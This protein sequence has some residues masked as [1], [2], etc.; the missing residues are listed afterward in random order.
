MTTNTRPWLNVKDWQ[1]LI[2]TKLKVGIISPDH[3]PI[4]IIQNNR[5]QGIAADYLSLLL[6]SPPEVKKFYS[7]KA[8]LRALQNGEIDILENGNMIEA[9]ERGAFFSTPYLRQQSVL[10][11]TVSD[12][13]NPKKSENILALAIE[14][15][16]TNEAKKHYPY[17]LKTYRSPLSA[18]EALALGDVDGALMEVSSAHY[19]IQ[20]RYLLDLQIENFS[21]LNASSFR[22]LFSPYQERLKAL[23]NQG[24][25]I[26]E[27]KYGET[28]RK[29]W[30]AGQHLNFEN[31]KISL[32]ATEKKWIKEN[33]TITAVAILSLGPLTQLDSNG[34][35]AGIAQDYL[36]IISQRSGLKINYIQAKNIAEAKKLLHDKK[37]LIT[38]YLPPE[39]VSSTELDTLPA[40]L[41]TSTVLMALD[42]GKNKHERLNG[43]KNLE[44]KKLAITEGYFLKERIERK[45]P[46]IKITTYQSTIEAM[47][48]VEQGSNDA[49]LT[50]NFIGPYLSMQYFGNNIKVAEILS[51]H[52][53]P[54]GIGV[55]KNQPS[56]KNILIKSQLTI[57]PEEV[58]Q[59]IQ[60]WRP[61]FAE[62]KKSFWQDHNEII[63]KSILSFA[64]LTSICLIW[65]F[66]LS[67]QIKR[68]RLAEKKADAANQ[69][70]S[71]FITTL[72][73]EIRNP[74]NA[75]IGLQEIALEKS[76]K[77]QNTTKILE[78]ANEAAQNILLLL[79][80]VLDL[81]RIESGKLEPTLQ[82]ANL[83]EVIEKSIHISKA[84][85]KQKKLDFNT[86]I[87]KNTNHFVYINLTSLNQIISNL[88]S[89][90]IKFTNTGEIK[91][92]AH[93]I[94]H[95]EIDKLWLILRITDSGVGIKAEDQKKLF[96]PFSQVGER[97]EAHSSGSGLGLSITQNLISLMNGHLI[98]HSKEGEG[99]CFTVKIP[100]SLA[101]EISSPLK[102]ISD[103]VKS[104]DSLSVLVAEDHPFN[105]LALSMQLESLGHKVKTASN[106]EDAWKLWKARH[107]DLIITDK[108]MPISSGLDLINRIRKEE[109]T[110]RASCKIIILTAS[111]EKNSDDAL[112]S[113]GADAIL[114][115]PTTTEQLRST[116][117]K[118]TKKT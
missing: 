12:P 73:H 55:V 11:Q 100:L 102:N 91:V 95:K 45:Y 46:E 86:F 50:N 76:K 25:P 66:Y 113:K 72:N 118:V 47:Q 48:S 3:P 17:V 53:I 117:S 1:W 28:I 78:T 34:E 13:F 52:P 62:G 58:S 70:K 107:F 31:P 114:Y 15:T 96:Q 8:A 27:R 29:N 82:T 79:S 5:Y 98:L 39:E 84:L 60:R 87:N 42:K 67:R 19:L 105:R 77:G 51:D 59:I 68:T 92:E 24:L 21:N 81:S 106:G 63:L 4:S 112:L 49:M 30:S 90:A 20:T 75:I 23:I 35:I 115:K 7:R 32:T 9:Q 85:A 111:A 36:K 80:N 10:V 65:F 16:T 110:N 89:N 97:T 44:G 54:L 93:T 104:L 56:L 94:A 18:L 6:P 64:S 40:Y 69:A 41:H 37:A 14:G 108:N 103:P 22:F 99:S 61:N 43:L 33:P 26:V 74:L 38:P 57:T 2:A 101:T 116:I 83:K 88:A 109:N 71:H